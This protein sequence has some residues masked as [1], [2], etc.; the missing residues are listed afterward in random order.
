[1][2]NCSVCG[3]RLKMLEGYNDFNGEYCKD[4]FG[5]TIKKKEKEKEDNLK[6]F[7]RGKLSLWMDERKRIFAWIYDILFGILIIVPILGYIVGIKLFFTP[8]LILVLLILFTL[9]LFTIIMNMYY[10]YIE[11]N[12]TS[13]GISIIL[14]Q[15][16]CV[17]LYYFIKL[18]PYWTKKRKSVYG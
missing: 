15:I 7:R 4:C 13:W 6:K 16:I 10:E 11:N 8:I 17:P 2:S 9:T 3:K 5:K 12:H 18:R 1:M 14:I